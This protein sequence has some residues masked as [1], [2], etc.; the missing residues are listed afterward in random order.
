[1]HRFAPK[2]VT[3]GGLRHVDINTKLNYNWY[4][5]KREERKEVLPLSLVS[6][7]RLTSLISSRYDQSSPGAL[8]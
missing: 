6:A 7:P 1:M 3:A 5:Q 2:P 4:K 8:L